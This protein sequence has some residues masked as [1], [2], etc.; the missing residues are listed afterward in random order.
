[1]CRK[2]A[3]VFAVRDGYADTVLFIFDFV[4]RL[5]LIKKTYEYFFRSLQKLHTVPQRMPR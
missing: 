3:G 2:E 4:H 1:M 5:G